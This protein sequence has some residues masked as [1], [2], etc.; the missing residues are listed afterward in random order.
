MDYVEDDLRKIGVKRWRI[1]AMDGT[2]WRKYVRLP[3]FFKSCR[4]M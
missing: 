3:R 4:A 1:K 2:E